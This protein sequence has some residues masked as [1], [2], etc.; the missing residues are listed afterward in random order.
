MVENRNAQLT[1]GTIIAAEGSRLQVQ[2][3]DGQVV[4]SR[5]ARRMG[6]IFGDIV[7]WRVALAVRSDGTGLVVERIQ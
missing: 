2:L 3:S 5:M 1:E 6:C 4:R 7:G